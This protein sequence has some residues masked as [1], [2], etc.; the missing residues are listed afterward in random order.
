MSAR[1]P[2]ESFEQYRIR[3]KTENIP[4]E[5]I[6]VEGNGYNRE[7]H[8]KILSQAK[9]ELASARSRGYSDSEILQALREGS[10]VQKKYADFIEYFIM[11]AG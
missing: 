11:K 3:R 5:T 9:K 4:K 1:F 8:R 10:Q 6:L 2:N 7:M